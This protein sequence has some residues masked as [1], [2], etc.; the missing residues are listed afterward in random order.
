MKRPSLYGITQAAAPRD[1][2][3]LAERVAFRTGG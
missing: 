2:L 3:P 1:E